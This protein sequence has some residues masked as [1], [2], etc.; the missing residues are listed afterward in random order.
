VANTGEQNDIKQ[1]D[2]EDTG[3]E[4]GE[5]EDEEGGA[6]AADAEDAEED[7]RREGREGDDV[8]DSTRF[9]ARTARRPVNRWQRLLPTKQGRRGARL[10]RGRGSG[11]CVDNGQIR[12][13]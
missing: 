1:D 6:E 8:E 3:D 12:R 4:Q 13:G 9:G 7:D 11:P 5:E 10:G 2:E